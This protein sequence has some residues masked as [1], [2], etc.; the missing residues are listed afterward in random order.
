MPLR[1]PALRIINFAFI[2]NIVSC[3]WHYS[4]N[5]GKRWIALRHKQHS[6]EHACRRGLTSYM[7]ACSPFCSSAASYDM[8]KRCASLSYCT[9]FTMPAGMDKQRVDG[10]Y[11]RAMTFATM[12]FS[13]VPA[14]SL[15]I[16]TLPIRC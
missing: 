15:G 9:F 8:A 6:D 1:I 13:G 3:A 12:P 10:G 2:N 7:L 14:L 5:M 4:A 11:I 16:Y